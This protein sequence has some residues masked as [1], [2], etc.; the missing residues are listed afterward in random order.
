MRSDGGENGGTLDADQGGG[1]V[2]LAN[3]KD[4]VCND[5]LE[6]GFAGVDGSVWK[7]EVVEWNVRAIKRLCEGVQ[8]SV[9]KLEGERESGGEETDDQRKRGNVAE[10]C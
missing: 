6:L 7:S 8:R 10:H 1:V 9:K 2:L 4:S 5:D 3:S